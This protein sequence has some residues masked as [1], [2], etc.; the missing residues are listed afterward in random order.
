MSLPEYKG[1]NMSAQII[2]IVN[3]KG[4]VGKTTS[5]A[6]MGEILSLF[7]KKVLLIDTD[8]SGNLSML[9]KHFQEDC[10]NVLNNLEAPEQLNI[11][12]IF[13]YRYKTEG[14]VQKTI[15]SVHQDLDIMPSSKRL[16]LIPD[17]LLLQS[18]SNNL[19]NN[20]ILKK[21]V[22][23]ISDKYDYIFIDT[24]PRNDILIVNSLMTSDYIVVPVRSEGFSFKGFRETLTT[25]ANLKEE[26]D[27]SAEFLGAYQT[28]AEKNTNIYK[29]FDAEYNKML[30]KKNLPC[31]RKDKTVN[32]LLSS[33]GDNLI[34]Y[35]ASSN[36]LYDYCM[37]LIAMDILD[38]ATKQLIQR[39]Y[40]LI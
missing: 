30:G 8:E 18:K 5:T 6:F 9:F 3:N 40:N 19:N 16:S 14:E 34:K 32:E 12:E 17:M 35:T 28:S 4:G 33:A 21:A 38:S 26:Y 2:S 27:I 36:V 15:Y 11:S 37:L 39:A 29:E 1:E 20:I 13:K 31:I 7:G 22:K 24:A 10:N 23:T 25:L